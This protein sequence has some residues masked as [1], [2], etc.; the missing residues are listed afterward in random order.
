MYQLLLSSRRPGTWSIN[1]S[2]V[3]LGWRPGVSTFLSF[4]KA[5]GSEYQFVILFHRLDA[6]GNDFS[7]VF[8]G[9]RHGLLTF[10]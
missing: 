8:Q 3:F 9:W 1:F 10:L 5:G 2:F 6:L 4:Y 7:F